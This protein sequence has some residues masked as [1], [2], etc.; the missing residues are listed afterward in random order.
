M[1]KIKS[2]S[3]MLTLLYI[4][5]ACAP[6]T[7]KE[8]NYT[9]EAVGYNE[10]AN[11]KVNVEV[12][13]DGKITSIT[14]EH[15]DSPELADQAIEQLTQDMIEANTYDVDYIAGATKTSEGFKAAVKSALTDN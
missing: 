7:F 5:A 2:I 8:G 6:N 12:N 4:L 14:A 13:T 15:K 3:I 9:G 11:I 10:D 1:K